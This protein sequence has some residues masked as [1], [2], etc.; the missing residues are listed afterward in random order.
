MCFGS[1][2]LRSRQGRPCEQRSVSHNQ[3]P[4]VVCNSSSLNGIKPPKITVIVPC[5]P[6]VNVAESQNTGIHK[7]RRRGMGTQRLKQVAVAQVSSPIRVPRLN[8]TSGV[9][10]LTYIIYM[11]QATPSKECQRHL[12]KNASASHSCCD[13]LNA[14]AMRLSLTSTRG[15]GTGNGYTKINKKKLNACAYLFTSE[16]IYHTKLFLIYLHEEGTVVHI[17]TRN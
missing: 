13:E 6:I 16:L 7:K 4:R 3:C 17:A 9:Y 1:S 2:I 15:L 11:P 12:V 10:T 14:F 5:P 8:T